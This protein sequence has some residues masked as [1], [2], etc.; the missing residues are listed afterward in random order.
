MLKIGILGGGQLGKMLLQK[1]ADYPVE[2]YV[3]DADPHAPAAHLSQHFVCEKVTDFHAVCELGRLVDVLTIEIENVNVEALHTLS[4]Q[5]KL[6]IPSPH[7]IETIRDKGLQKEFLQKHGIPTAPFKLTENKRDLFANIDFIPAVHKL[8]SGGYDGRGVQIIKDKNDINHGFD[9][10]SVLEKLVD[11]EKE[12]S[13]IVARN[14]KGETSLFPPAEMV[15]DPVY[16][17]VD[18]LISP[19]TIGPQVTEQ[20]YSLAQQVCNALNSPGIFAIEMFLSKTGELLVNEIAP[21]V[22]NSGHHTIEANY[23][24]QFD[25]LLRILQNLPLGQPTPI[26]P[27]IMINLVG[28]PGYHGKAKYVGLEKVL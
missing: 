2:T 18:Y 17:L 1:A 14:T 24:S 13:V 22:H 25:A 26:K 5:G 19:A 6:I 15:F 11:I 3:L 12:I 7:V 9:E 4:Q 10:P 28:E 27:S 21:R 23:V 8:R 20:A 16:H